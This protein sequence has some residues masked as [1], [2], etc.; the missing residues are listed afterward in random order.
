MS[1][2]T[3][4]DDPGT[5]AGAQSDDDR[6]LPT[7]TRRMA[8]GLLGLGVLA[9][10]E[11]T[12]VQGDVGGGPDS[13]ELAHVL[14]PTYEGPESELPDP[15]VTGRRFTV[16]DT[17]GTY[18]QWTEL[19]DTGSAWV[20]INI[21]LADATADSVNTDRTHTKSAESTYRIHTDGST[22]YADGPTGTVAEAS[23][24]AAA[25]Q[26]AIDD[27]TAGDSIF[28]HPGTYDFPTVVDVHT[29]VDLLSNF[30]TLNLAYDGKMFKTTISD[31]DDRYVRTNMRVSGFVAR[32][33]RGSYP[34][35]LFW[36]SEGDEVNVQIENNYIKE[37]GGNGNAAGIYLGPG[38]SAVYYIHNN[39]MKG[40]N[41]WGV[42]TGSSQFNFFT[43]NDLGGGIRVRGE[44][45]NWI[46]GNS[47]FESTTMGVDLDS[48]TLVGWNLIVDNQE[49][50]IESANDI[51]NVWIKNNFVTNNSLASD[52]GHDGIFI[53]GTSNPKER[54]QII[55]N[56]CWNKTPEAT[57]SNQGIQR[58][59]LQIQGTW[60][61]CVIKNNSLVGNGTG[62]FFWNDPGISG[63]TIIE[64]NVGLTSAA[65]GT[66]T[67]PS[68]GSSVSVT[69]G[70]SPQLQ[71]FISLDDYDLTLVSAPNGGGTPYVTDATLNDGS[72]TVSLPA[73]PSA[74]VDVKWSIDVP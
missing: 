29:P 51:H 5:D 50:G 15:G 7:V 25:T 13:D 24:A 58:Y 19:R 62:P 41:D 72:F 59:G 34:N 54:V 52:N 60:T 38:T 48:R 63:D 33:N 21:E 42:A 20:P 1:Q 27:S 55:G 17:G 10:G 56:L 35:G 73:S 26:A 36:S 65:K 11:T 18:P 9:G 12:A 49:A 30:A 44:G 22:V 64:D 70:I 69:H 47:I 16:T 39:S 74:D 68:S 53:R 3:P 23:D 37:W 32:G 8:L 4:P 28:F 57:G 40:M 2:D 46:L 61:N 6:G 14:R 67:V 66:A 71:S 45:E 43:F 31:S